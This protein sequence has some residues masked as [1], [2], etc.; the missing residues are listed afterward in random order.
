ML[1]YS[2]AVEINQ[3]VQN[4]PV[5]MTNILIAI[6]CFYYTLYIDSLIK[7]IYYRFIPQMVVTKT[8]III[9]WLRRNFLLV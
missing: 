7:V 8:T 4:H 1:F 2:K 5:Y 3:Q 9:V 6:I